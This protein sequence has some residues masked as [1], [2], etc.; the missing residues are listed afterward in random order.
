[1]N[2]R[3][4]PVLLFKSIDSMSLILSLVVISM[5]SGF[6]PVQADE[7]SGRL[8]TMEVSE[9]KANM[10]QLELMIGEK[11]SLQDQNWPSKSK[12]T[13]DF[14]H[15]IMV[16]SNYRGYNFIKYKGVFYAVDR[17]EGPLDVAQVKMIA[18]FPWFSDATSAQALR[19]I[20]DEKGTPPP[21]LFAKIWNRVKRM[22]RID[23][24]K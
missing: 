14:I 24:A 22:M 16:E 20:I 13:E 9:M 12:V 2:V 15:P 7:L 5:L 6:L 21:G 19:S 3:P 4:I 18:K 17:R 11:Y 23:T 10:E 1:M 8:A